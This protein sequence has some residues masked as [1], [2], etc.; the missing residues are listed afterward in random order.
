VVLTR[1][2]TGSAYYLG[3][4]LDEEGMRR[5]YDAIPA[6]R[7]AV[8]PADPDGGV[9][10]VV[11]SSPGHDYEF[12]INHADTDRKVTLAGPGYDVLSGQRTDR[13]LTLGR[14]GVAIVRRDR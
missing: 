13:A 7:S 6:L 5:I 11:R 10:R 8:R 12:L 2:G 4:R 1:Y 14:R 9:E 3:A